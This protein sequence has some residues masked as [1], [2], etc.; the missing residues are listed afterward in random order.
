MR[1]A[2]ESMFDTPDNVDE[3]VELDQTRVGRLSRMDA[4]QLQAMAK[5]GQA[6]ARLELG[7][8]DAALRRLEEGTCGE[9]LDCG[10]AIAERRLDANPTADRC[11]GC[12]EAREEGRPS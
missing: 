4:M 2:I 11:V 12:A 8:I 1:S 9:C 3:V 6:R 5:A 10:E 7:R